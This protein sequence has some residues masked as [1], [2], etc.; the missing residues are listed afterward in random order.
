MKTLPKTLKAANTEFL[1][2]PAEIRKAIHGLAS[3]A[4][5]LD[6]AVAFIGPEWQR[7]LANYP[8]AIRAISWL[9]H[10]A[11]DPDAV[12]S[13]ISRQ[14][15]FVKQR[16]GLHAKVYFAS[17]VG[18]VVGSADLSRPALADVVDA[19]QCEAAILV[20]EPELLAEISK[21]FGTLWNDHLHTTKITDSNL[22][23]VREER[24]KFPV[25]WPH[26]VNNVPPP[27]D[28][29]PPWV[30]RIAK[31]VR[32]IPLENKFENYREQLQSLVSKQSVSAKDVAKLADT[33]AEW[34][35]HR[36]V[37]KNFEEHSRKKTLDG[38]R[39]LF[40]EGRDIYDRLTEINEKGLLKG[41]RIPAISLL[42]YWSLPYAYPP[43]NAKTKKFLENSKMDSAGMSASSPACYATWLGFAELL[44]AKLHL[45]SVG[46]IDRIVTKYYDSL[47]Q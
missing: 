30:I 23:R 8:G 20:H 4:K 18:A 3:Q 15:T 22:E 31:G 36:A 43:F 2:N 19:P 13:L 35:K 5:S 47:K 46:H 39:T 16:N 42:L 9:T 7:L 45:P 26:T 34:T 41:L 17:G 24:K 27:P 14:K 37:Y 33:L 28:V 1:A 29:L 12:K 11:T 25:Q 44:R 38:L 21:W 32:Q 6:L 40:D 10:P